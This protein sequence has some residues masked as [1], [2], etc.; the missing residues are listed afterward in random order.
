MNELMS[1]NYQ[2]EPYWQAESDARLEQWLIK[3][4]ELARIECIANE[5]ITD[6]QCH[7]VSND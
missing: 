5:R 3:Q 7:S 1:T 4:K 6:N 2:R